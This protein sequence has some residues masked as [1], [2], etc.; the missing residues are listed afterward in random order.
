MDNKKKEGRREVKEQRMGD[1]EKEEEM[2]RS[3]EGGNK[4]GRM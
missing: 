3:T 4:R 2:N 1:G